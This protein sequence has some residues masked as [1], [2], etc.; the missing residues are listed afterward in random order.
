MDIKEP[1]WPEYF[2][3]DAT[4]NF[5][6]PKKRINESDS[7]PKQKKKRRQNVNS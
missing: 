1:T 3:Q 2:N 6:N 4:K 5:K 7:D